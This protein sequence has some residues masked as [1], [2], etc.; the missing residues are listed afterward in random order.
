MQEYS[1]AKS[2]MKELYQIRKNGDGEVDAISP[3]LF[4]LCILNNSP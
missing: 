1:S 3:S 2:D 4:D